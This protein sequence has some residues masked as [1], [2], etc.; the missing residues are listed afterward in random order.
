MTDHTPHVASVDD[1]AG[2]WS[3]ICGDGGTLTEAQRD[4]FVYASDLANNHTDT[5][6]AAILPNLT[7]AEIG[8]ALLRGAGDSQLVAAFGL[9]LAHEHWLGYGHLRHHLDGGWNWNTHALYLRVSWQQLLD[10]IDDG[11]VYGSSSEVAILRIAA[12]IAGHGGVNLGNDTANLDNTNRGYVLTA[13]GHLL[14]HGGAV[15]VTAGLTW[16]NGIGNQTKET[17]P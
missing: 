15:P 5:E 4:Q 3:C 13:V 1:E 11:S 9:L 12:S 16:T 8:V 6:L 2:T 14:T 17:H 10:G 7:P